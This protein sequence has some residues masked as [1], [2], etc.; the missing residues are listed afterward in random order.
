MLAT[1]S[2]DGACVLWAWESGVQVERLE[3]PPGA[4][5]P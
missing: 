4:L 2:E 1:T 3:L 5:K